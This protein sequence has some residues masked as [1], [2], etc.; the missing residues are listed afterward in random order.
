MRIIEAVNSTALEVEQNF[1][2]VMNTGQNF[3]SL[4]VCLPISS[5][6]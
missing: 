3:L 6:P 1:F 5:Q 2:A 4:D